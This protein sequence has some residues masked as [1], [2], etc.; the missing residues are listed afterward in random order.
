V[1]GFDQ[2]VNQLGVL[3]IKPHENTEDVLSFGH[4][5]L[6]GICADN[7]RQ[8][9]AWY[10]AHVVQDRVPVILQSSVRHPELVIWLVYLQDMESLSSCA[11][12]AIY[13]GHSTIRIPFGA[14]GSHCGH[15]FRMGPV[16]MCYILVVILNPPLTL[17]LSEQGDNKAHQSPRY[18]NM[19]WFCIVWTFTY[20]GFFI[21][22]CAYRMLEGHAWYNFLPLCVFFR[23]SR[24]ELLIMLLYT[25]ESSLTPSCSTRHCH[26]YWPVETDEKFLRLSLPFF[27]STP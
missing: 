23:A 20:N 2:S 21:A 3:A 18:R 17:H 15:L 1:R 16:G 11:L 14:Q 19:R 7:F 24:S 5:L 22:G 8:S 13:W 10:S 6:L 4:A 27:L 9:P 26:S 12:C 25:S